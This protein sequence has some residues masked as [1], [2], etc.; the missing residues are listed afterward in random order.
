MKEVVLKCSTLKIKT[1]IHLQIKNSGTAKGGK[2]KWPKI[3][4]HDMNAINIEASSEI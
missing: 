1:P 4:L 2:S 3:Y